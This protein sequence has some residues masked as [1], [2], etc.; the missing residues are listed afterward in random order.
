MMSRA[1]VLDSLMVMSVWEKFERQLFI[2]II[3]LDGFIIWVLSSHD[4]WDLS[5]YTADRGGDDG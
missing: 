2:I 5:V 3:W 4:H 1:I